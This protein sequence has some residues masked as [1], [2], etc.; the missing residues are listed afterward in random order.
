M[1]RV[2]RSFLKIKLYSVDSFKLNAVPFESVIKHTSF[3]P[4]FSFKLK[5]ENFL[6]ISRLIFSSFSTRMFQIIICRLFFLFLIPGEQTNYLRDKYH[7]YMTGDGRMNMCG[8]NAEN[9]D[10]VAT[11]IH[12]T[13]LRGA[14]GDE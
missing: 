13:V 7:I 6:M 5:E 12:E 9:I 2:L 11:A 1:H 8:L 14:K 10:Y 4:T 3:M